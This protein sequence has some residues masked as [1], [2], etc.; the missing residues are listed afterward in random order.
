[1]LDNDW[2]TFHCHKT[3]HCNKGGTWV[4]D[5]EY[6][7]SGEEAMCTGAVAYL[8]KVGRPTV[9]MRM[10]LMEGSL[11]ADDFVEANNITIDPMECSIDD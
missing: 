3:V 2:S 1:M 5:G 8:L 11:K 9:G 4:D 6:Q 7:P 10:A